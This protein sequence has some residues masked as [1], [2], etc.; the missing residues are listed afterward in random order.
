MV[1][2][3]AHI[4]LI[5]LALAV[6]CPLVAEMMRKDEDLI[7]LNKKLEIALT[8]VT[9]LSGL[10]PICS[11]CKKIRDD[12]GYWNTLET[13]L[14]THSKLEFSQGICPECAEKIYPRYAHV[15]KKDTDTSSGGTVDG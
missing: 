4:R 12:Q 6:G 9:D 10:V 15:S 13:Y 14:K 3:G 8:E 2:F 11:N 1:A 5:N 7:L